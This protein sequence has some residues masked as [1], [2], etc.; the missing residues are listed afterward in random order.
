M[1]DRFVGRIGRKFADSAIRSAA[2]DSVRDPARAMAACPFLPVSRWALATKRTDF[3]PPETAVLARALLAL[4]ARVPS[5]ALCVPAALTRWLLSHLAS[6]EIT[7]G[8]VNFSYC[9]RATDASSSAPKLFVKQALTYLKWQPSMA[10]ER[11]RMAREVSGPPCRRSA[12]RTAPR[13][14]RNFIYRCRT[15]AR[16]RRSSAGL[17]PA[18][19]SPHSITSTRVTSCS[20]SSSS[21]GAH[22]PPP[23]PPPPMPPA[24]AL[25]VRLRIV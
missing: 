25:S 1:I 17:L 19:S 4:Y 2:W 11:E 14:S 24:P 10:L 20:F 22:P 8:N 7:D 12:T 5:A 6:R 15:T 13:D 21:T 18:D 9:V 16:R 3:A 23:T